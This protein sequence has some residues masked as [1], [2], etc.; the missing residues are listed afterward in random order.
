[1]TSASAAGLFCLVLTCAAL[2]YVARRF[3]EDLRVTTKLHGYDATAAGPV[4]AYLPGYLVEGARDHI[5]LGA[6]FA[7]AVGQ[8]IPWPSARAAFPALAMNTLFP[9]LSV[10]DPRRADYVVTWGVRPGRLAPV[11]RTWVAR[12]AAGS[13]PAVFVGRVAR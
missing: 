8:R 10:G 3:A 6:T 1:M 9:R 7:T 5:P 12:A 11:A 13:Y 4:Q 2:P